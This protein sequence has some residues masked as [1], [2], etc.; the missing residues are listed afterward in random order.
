MALDP[1]LMSTEILVLAAMRVRQHQ[2][3]AP[4]RQVELRIVYYDMLTGEE[5]LGERYV[6]AVP[7][8][9]AC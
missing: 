6:Y 9:G 5:E 2:V 1:R 4:P 3:S 8:E 7:A